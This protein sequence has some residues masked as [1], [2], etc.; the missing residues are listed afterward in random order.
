MVIEV[1]LA[2]T[3]MAAYDYDLRLCRS[4]PTAG[5]VSKLYTHQSSSISRSRPSPEAHYPTGSPGA[6]L[7]PAGLIKQET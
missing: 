1:K 7:G 3:G 4:I 5:P 2:V 6:G